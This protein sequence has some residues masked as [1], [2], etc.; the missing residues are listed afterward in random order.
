MWRHPEDAASPNSSWNGQGQ[1]DLNH[2]SV[3]RGRDADSIVCTRSARRQNSCARRRALG[4]CCARAA[5][6][7]NNFSAAHPKKVISAAAL[8][9][10]LEMW[11]D[12]SQEQRYSQS[13]SFG[14]SLDYFICKHLWWSFSQKSAAQFRF[15]L[16]GPGVGWWDLSFFFSATEQPHLD[17]SQCIGSYI[18]ANVLYTSST[19]AKNNSGHVYT[20]SPRY[21][22]GCGR[23]PFQSLLRWGTNWACDG[24]G[25]GFWLAHGLSAEGLQRLTTK[26]P[27]LQHF[28]VWLERRKRPFLPSW[29]T[30]APGGNLSSICVYLHY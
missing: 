12:L 14:T 13:S 21:G 19:K 7:G 25:E 17:Y 23:L 11:E 10:I 29:L 9:N 16:S 8:Q 27:Q 30:T 24:D 20:G 15:H 5:S 26:A 2:Q 6:E 22:S 1:Y 4:S 28:L 3:P 18:A